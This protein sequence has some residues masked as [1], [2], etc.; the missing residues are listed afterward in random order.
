MFKDQ[1]WKFILQYSKLLL[2]A[3]VVS[4]L[5]FCLHIPATQ[6]I[7]F[8]LLLLFCF[9]IVIFSGLCTGFQISDYKNFFNEN[10]Y[11]IFLLILAIITFF[12]L[13]TDSFLYY[14]EYYAFSSS[15]SGVKSGL[16][17]SRLFHGMLGDLFSYAFPSKMYIIRTFTTSMGLLFSI[18]LFS[19]IK[20]HSKNEKFAFLIT[21]II[22]LSSPIVD[23][24]AYTAILSY[25][26]GLVAASVSVVLFE[27][28]LNCWKHFKKKSICLFFIVLILIFTAFQCYQLAL[29]IIFL[30]F[31]IYAFYATERKKLIQFFFIY[32]L[33]FFISI[34]VT[35][36]SNYLMNINGSISNRGKII[37]SFIEIIDKVKWFISYILP[38]ALNRIL[39]AF[40]GRFLFSEKNYWYVLSFRNLPRRFIFLSVSFGWFFVIIGIIS[41]YFKQ[42]KVLETIFLIL[43]L[44][45]TYFVYLILQEYAYHT[46]YAYSLILL[47]LFYMFIGLNWLLELIFKRKEKII[48]GIFISLII[49]SMIQTNLYIRQFWI[50]ENQSSYDYLKN[51]II[52]SYQRNQTKWIHV[53]GT[54][55]ANQSDVYSEF[56]VKTVIKEIDLNPNDFKITVSHNEYY[57]RIIEGEVFK[58]VLTHLT[59]DEKNRML[60]Y[61]DY[62]ETYYNYTINARGFSALLD[63]QNIFRKVGLLPSNNEMPVL[64]VDLRWVSPVWNADLFIDNIYESIFYYEN[65]SA[66]LNKKIILNLPIYDNIEVLRNNVQDI[67]IDKITDNSEFKDYIVLKCGNIDPKINL[68]FENIEKPIGK[69]YIGIT[70]KNSK[71][72]LLQV[73]YNYGKGLTEKK[74]Y[75]LY[76]L[77]NENEKTVFLPVV[78]WE[79]RL[80]LVGIRIDPPDDTEF[81]IREINILSL[82]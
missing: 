30:M 29:P 41:Y 13:F 82:E 2:L 20:K 43:C 77:N 76:I 25:T 65:E 50:A 71:E 10:K 57:L 47:L 12:P 49:L 78:G 28:A 24:I 37:H 63:L 7:F 81:Y 5:V 66:P 22:T 27:R 73:F 56:A 74:S 8:T 62:G 80:K 64:I 69:S 45:G 18:I 11:N 34:V 23:C 79:N 60:S 17:F 61:Y 75:R 4:I 21:C 9:S 36:L 70:Y 67:L 40:Y 51:T 46:Y 16:Y 1:K 44:P 59:S 54:P 42:K 14:D 52:T 33:F 39:A 31:A 3:F 48:D 68:T 58:E 15:G 35:F 55:N 72:G 26:S 53:Y 32:M 6:S 38:N 19:W